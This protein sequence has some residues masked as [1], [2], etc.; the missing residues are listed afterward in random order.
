MSNME[1]F[2]HWCTL[3]RVVEGQK[4]GLFRLLCEKISHKTQQNYSDVNF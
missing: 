3:S 2:V 1:G 4:Q